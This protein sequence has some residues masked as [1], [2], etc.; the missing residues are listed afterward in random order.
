MVTARVLGVPFA[1]RARIVNADKEK[2][3]VIFKNV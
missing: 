1:M 2:L 3:A